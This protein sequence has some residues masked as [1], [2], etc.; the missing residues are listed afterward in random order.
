MSSVITISQPP[1]NPGDKSV[2]EMPTEMTFAPVDPDIDPEE[3][4]LALSRG[5]ASE[6]EGS[7]AENVRKETKG[8]ATTTT[9]ISS[10][11]RNGQGIAEAT[12]G[13]SMSNNTSKEDE[14][15]LDI[16][17]LNPAQASIRRRKKPN[18]PDAVIVLK[19]ERASIYIRTTIIY[20]PTFEFHS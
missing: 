7:D 8:K 3:L 13:C 17:K 18:G 20:P 15:K 5:T 2:N 12:V 9:K 14:E 1:S 11:L 6:S 10:Q 19:E 4:D 16:R